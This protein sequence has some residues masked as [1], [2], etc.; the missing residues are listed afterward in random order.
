MTMRGRVGSWPKK[1]QGGLYDDRKSR[2][3]PIINNKQS[4]K[5]KTLAK[6]KIKMEGMTSKGHISSFTNHIDLILSGGDSLFS[7]GSGDSLH[8]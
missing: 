1:A 7:Y 8:A 3:K 5:W 2:R 4:K 6:V